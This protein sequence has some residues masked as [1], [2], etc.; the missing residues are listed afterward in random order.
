MKQTKRQSFIEAGIQQ[1]IGFAVGLCSQLLIFPVFDIE[2][3][4]QSNLIITLYFA[5]ISYIRSYYVRRFFNSMKGEGKN[6]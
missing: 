4:L 6:V 2:I 5:I 3:N 1:I